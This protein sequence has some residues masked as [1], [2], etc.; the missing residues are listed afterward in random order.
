MGTRCF[1]QTQALTKSPP[2]LAPLPYNSNMLCLHLELLKSC[3]IICRELFGL[4]I[5]YRS[6]GTVVERRRYIGAKSEQEFGTLNYNV[7]Q[8]CFYMAGS[9]TG[10]SD[11]RRPTSV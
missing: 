2:A 10:L 3:R 8:C 1:A 5:C 9:Q 7:C 6:T 11:R 4:N